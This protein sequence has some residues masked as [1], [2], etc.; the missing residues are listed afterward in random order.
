M[1]FLLKI[2]LFKQNMFLLELGQNCSAAR[3]FTGEKRQQSYGHESGELK[4][5]RRVSLK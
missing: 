4:I 3:S 1:L 2:R 5:F